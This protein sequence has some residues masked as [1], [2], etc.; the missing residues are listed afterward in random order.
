MG[1]VNVLM[2]SPAI[3]TMPKLHAASRLSLMTRWGAGAQR[4]HTRCGRQLKKG[5][6]R[7]R[8]VNR[9]IHS[10]SSTQIYRSSVPRPRLSGRPARAHLRACPAPQR[11]AN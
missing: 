1:R 10:R 9:D 4:Q 2:A 8:R 11:V 5:V 3:N 7:R 6:G